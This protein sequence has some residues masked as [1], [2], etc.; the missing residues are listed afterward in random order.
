MTQ[1]KYKLQNDLQTLEAGDTTPQQKWDHVVKCTHK[2]S[3]EV[4]GY[5]NKNKRESVNPI[6]KQLSE[7]Q[8][9]IQTQINKSKN[10]N[11]CTVLRNERNRIMNRMHRILEQEKH[12]QI[13]EDIREVEKQKMTL[14]KCMLPYAF[15]RRKRNVHK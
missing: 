6:I 2:A 14:A 7:K 10:N 3:E 13:L 11:K 4:L 5:Q 12:S 1:Y 15:Y 8:R 9:E